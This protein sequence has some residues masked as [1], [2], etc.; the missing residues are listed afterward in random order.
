MERASRPGKEG[1]APHERPARPTQEPCHRIPTGFRHEPRVPG[2][3]GLP[4]PGSNPERVPS[5]GVPRRTQ[6]LQDWP[7]RVG[8]QGSENSGLMTERRWRSPEDDGTAP[9][10]PYHGD[11]EGNDGTGETNFATGNRTIREC[12]LRWY[13]LRFRQP[14]GGDGRS[15]RG[16]GRFGNV[17]NQRLFALNQRL[18]ALNQRLSAPNQRLSPPNQRLSPPNQR[19]SP[20]NQRLSPP[21]QRLSPPNQRLFPP[22]QRLFGSTQ[23]LIRPRRAVGRGKRR[24]IRA[25]R[26]LGQRRET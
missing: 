18:F 4:S 10:I 23:P 26:G 3:L 21:N 8:T 19:L 12:R 20:P 9:R 2:T 25:H 17:R 16:H 1:L 11:R 15:P 6:S 22:N 7:P 14:P 5:S 13:F 24:A